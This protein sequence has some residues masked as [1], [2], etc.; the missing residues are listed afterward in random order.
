MPSA[1][2]NPPPG[3]IRFTHNTGTQQ[4]QVKS[5]IH[6]QV[7]QICSVSDAGTLNKDYPTYV[8]LANTEVYV[9]ESVADAI[10]AINPSSS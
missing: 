8:V 6:V 10:N 2:P 4:R 1:S 5:P 3:W 7:S 9:N